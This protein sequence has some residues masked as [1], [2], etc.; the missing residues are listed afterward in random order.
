MGQ[1]NSKVIP[2]YSQTKTV[3]SKKRTKSGSLKKKKKSVALVSF[4]VNNPLLNGGSTECLSESGWQEVCDTEAVNYSA[5]GTRDSAILVSD[6]RRRTDISV[7]TRDS[8]TLVSD[9]RRRTDIS[10]P[11][12]RIFSD[13]LEPAASIKNTPAGKSTCPMSSGVKQTEGIP[14]SEG[15]STLPICLDLVSEETTVAGGLQEKLEDPHKGNKSIKPEMKTTTEV[16]KSVLK[17]APTSSDQT[18][19]REATGLLYT[20]DNISSPH[21]SVDLPGSLM[22]DSLPSNK[23]IIHTHQ[24]N[25]TVLSSSTLPFNN[26]CVE[27]NE[28]ITSHQKA[29]T[30]IIPCSRSYTNFTAEIK[31]RPPMSHSD[32]MEMI[33]EG[34]SNQKRSILLRLPKI[35][36]GKPSIGRNVRFQELVEDSAKSASM[37]DIR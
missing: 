18:N 25:V 7:G 5:V 9:K 1:P 2:S 10:L 6:K 8:T 3:T 24:N 22:T 27:N 31:Q 35:R 30:R 11:P 33:R 32:S 13:R 21:Q 23:E 26:E 16:S 14:F 17:Q 19:V 37:N 4:S 29:F 15:N 34:A 28:A 20:P 12:S 36:A